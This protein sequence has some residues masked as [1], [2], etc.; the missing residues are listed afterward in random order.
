MTGV[1]STHHVLG[2]PHLLSQLWDSEGDVLLGPTRGE[3]C[4]THHEKVKT[5]E[6][7][8]INSKL[9]KVGVQL[10]REPQTTCYPTHSSRDQMVKVTNYKTRGTKRKA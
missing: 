4:K 8:Q 3:W 10:A 7:D 1:S 5:W 9:P 6:G 2:I